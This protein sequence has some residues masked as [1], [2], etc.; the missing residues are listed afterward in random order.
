MSPLLQGKDGSTVKKLLALMIIFSLVFLTTGCPS[1]TTPAKKPTPPA[2]EKTKP[3]EKQ[4]E[5]K[6]PEEKKPEEKKP[7]EKKPEEKQPEEKKPEEK[8]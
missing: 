1:A 5:E 3:E 6:K 2:T 7:E 8:K 4:P